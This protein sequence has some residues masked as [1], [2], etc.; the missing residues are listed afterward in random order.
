MSTNR[1]AV[2][3]SRRDNKQQRTHSKNKAALQ[4]R[5]RSAAKKNIKV[6][7]LCTA[8]A[9][10][11]RNEELRAEQFEEQQRLCNQAKENQGN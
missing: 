9:L 7:E 3:Y 2:H 11:Q 10:A 6:P 5:D 1:K 4:D 8:A